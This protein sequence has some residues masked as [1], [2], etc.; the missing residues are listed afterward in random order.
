MNQHG[1]MRRL[2]SPIAALAAVAGMTVALA[3]PAHADPMNSI[4][5]S[6]QGSTLSWTPASSAGSE[7]VFCP[8]SIV[9]PGDCTDVVGW[10]PAPATQYA[11]A[12]DGLT[13]TSLSLGMSVNAYSGGGLSG[14]VP[15]PAGVYGVVV[16]REDGTYSN[17]VRVAVPT[18][19]N[20][21]PPPDLLQE[22]GLPSSGTC[23]A[24]DD[25]A[26]NWGGVP[27]GG[28]TKSWAQWAVPVTGGGVCVRTL[29]FNTH[30]YMWDVR[31]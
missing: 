20:R 11:F 5:L 31:R 21:T 13:S 12:V 16:T 26:L 30:T 1:L 18:Y 27:S 15:L 10:A 23:D 22:V 28:W 25:K 8:S 14:V 19:D 24:I 17:L 4:I 9:N 29:F 3:G 7:L 6:A 2:A